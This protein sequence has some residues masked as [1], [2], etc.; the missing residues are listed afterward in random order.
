MYKALEQT[1]DDLHNDKAVRGV[2]FRSALDRDIYTAGNDINALFAPRTTLA[3]YREYWVISNRFLAKLLSSPLVTVAAIKGACP[4]GGC[5]LALC[6]DYRIMKSG[7]I[8]LNEVALA[9]PV[10]AYWAR[11]MS[12]AIGEGEAYRMCTLAR[13][14]PASRALQIGLIDEIHE[15]VDAQARRFMN[16]TLKLPDVGRIAT[17][18]SFRQSLAQEMGDEKRLAKEADKSWDKLSSKETVAILTAVMAKLSKKG[19]RKADGKL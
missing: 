2:I 14:I 15:D 12:S 13:Q 11:L 5:V 7:S 4:A 16:E 9:I 18:M 10:P 1:L 8:G 17:K 6:C 19:K 3:R